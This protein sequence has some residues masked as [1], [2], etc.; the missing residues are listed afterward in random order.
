M[1]FALAHPAMAISHFDEV[2]PFLP[3]RGILPKDKK[4]L[5]ALRAE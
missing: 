5:P 1:S 2:V 3:P 4:L